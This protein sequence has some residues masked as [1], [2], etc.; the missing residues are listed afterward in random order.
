MSILDK[1]VPLTDLKS[2][3]LWVLYGKSGSGKT[4]LLSTFPKPLLYV[5]I[6]DDGSNTIEPTEDIRCVEVNSI[7]DAETLAKELAKDT[8][9]KTVALDT[10]SLIVNEWI[11]E[12]AVK[13]KK[14]VSQQMWGDLKTDTEALTRMYQK[15]AKDRI[16]VLT[17]HESTDS[18]EGMEDEIMPDIRPSVSKGARTYLEAMANYGIHCTVIMREKTLPDG[19]TEDVEAHAIHLAPNPYYWVKTQKPASIKLP[20]LVVNPSYNKI[21]KLIKGEKTN[22]KKNKS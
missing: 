10:Y 22:G 1:A 16:V 11:D 21:M 9:Y 13:K 17:C 12:N 20:R 19:S 18:F 14:R 6:G 7:T 4:H 2:S 15:L 3:N 8:Y 5:R